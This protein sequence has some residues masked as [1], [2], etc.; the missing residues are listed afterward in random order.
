MSSRPAAP[1]P[2][3]GDTSTHPVVPTA[4]TPLTITQVVDKVFT[5]FDANADGSISLTELLSVLDPTGTH[6]DVATKAAALLAEVDSNGDTT[7]NKTE[8]TAVVTK[9][10]TN[11]DGRIDRS[12]HVDGS[13]DDDNDVL[14]L[15]MHGRGPHGDRPAPTPLSTEALVD[16]LLTRFDAN[17]DASITLTELLSGLDADDEHHVG[18]TTL[19]EQMVKDL[20]SNGDGSLGTVELTAAVDALDVNQNGLVDFA[21]MGPVAPDSAAVDLV[22]L[23][24]HHG[25]DLPGAAG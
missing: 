16:R 4:P 2:S 12:D 23:L 5:R 15:L 24:M 9:L 7:L 25:H 10:D 21:E 3:I 17:D 13:S 14:Q 8:V 6:T 22:G 18:L 11:L 20:D 19:V 1:H